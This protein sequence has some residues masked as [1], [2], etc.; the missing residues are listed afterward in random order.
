M[1]SQFCTCYNV[2]KTTYKYRFRG[3][4]SASLAVK[5]KAEALLPK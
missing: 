2:I 1:R 5:G 3:N 4:K